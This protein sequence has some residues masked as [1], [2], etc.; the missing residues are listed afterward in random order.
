MDQPPP[1]TPEEIAAAQATN[2]SQIGE[3]QTVKIFGILHLVFGAFGVFS[4]VSGLIVIFIGNPFTALLPQTPELAAQAQAQAEMEKQMLP[5]NVVVTC[6]TIV[7]TFLII[8]AGITLLKKRRSA[9]KWSN[10]YAI[11][12]IILKIITAILTVTV[13]YPAMKEFMTPPSAAGSHGAFEAGMIGGMLI[14]VLIPVI[15]PILALVLLNRPN[16]KDWFASRPE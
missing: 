15:Y 6:L 4:V 13:T 14:G 8:T 2:Y 10:R 7:V 3:P 12:S 9:L 5:M 1:L 11:S 16:T